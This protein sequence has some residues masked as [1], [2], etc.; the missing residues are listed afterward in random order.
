MK[1]KFPNEEKEILMTHKKCK[2]MMEK[3]PPP[4]NPPEYDMFAQSEA[5]AKLLTAFSQR[6]GLR[7]TVTFDTLVVIYRACSYEMAIHRYSPWCQLFDNSELK[8]LDYL[9]DISEY[10]DAYG[11]QR[12]HGTHQSIEHLLTSSTF[13]NRSAP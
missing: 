6:N 7:F 12:S 1:Q 13:R 4:K 2:K 10:F 8:V 3:N 9:M 5:F 11:R